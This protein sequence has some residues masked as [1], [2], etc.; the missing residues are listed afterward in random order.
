MSARRIPQSIAVCAILVLSFAATGPAFG[1]ASSASAWSGCAQYITVQAGDTLQGIAA[2]CGTTVEALLAANPG[3][4]P[5]LYA[6]QVLYIPTG[7]A[8]ATVYQNVQAGGGTY[9]VQRGDTLGEIAARYNV[10][11]W[12]I[13][14]VNP[15]ISNPNLIYP[16]Q[17]INLPARA[18]TTTVY[19]PPATNYPTAVPAPSYSTG[20]S[21]L[22]VVY[23]H[24]LLVRTGPSR[25][26]AEIKSSLVSA[27]KGSTWQY[28]K[29]S[30]TIDSEGFVW[31]EVLL[32]QTVN[33]LSTG[34]I[35]VKD[36]LGGYYTEPNINL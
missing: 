10:A 7:Y 17:V 18:G 6:G 4:I 33:G 24:G 30:V 19:Y 26:Y 34:W 13:L 15:Q 1:G 32:S 8:S 11:L 2:N 9:V 31:V 22:K 3:L 27:V 21:N 14:A 36:G 25:N 23:K 35:I 12:E 5:L 28:R 20:Y 29:N 16:G